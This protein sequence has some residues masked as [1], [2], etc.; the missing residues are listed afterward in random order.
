MLLSGSSLRLSVA[1]AANSLA[2]AS[3]SLRCAS[4]VSCLRLGGIPLAE[5]VD[6]QTNCDHECNSHRSDNDP[7]RPRRRLAAGQ[8]VL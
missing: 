1:K 6:R 8:D 2:L 4:F 3:R 7:L 5:G